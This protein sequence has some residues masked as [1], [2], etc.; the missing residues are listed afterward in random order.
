MESK[1]GG[2]KINGT[3]NKTI[4]LSRRLLL[5][6][7]FFLMGASIVGGLP[8]KVGSNITLI[9]GFVSGMTIVSLAK[10]TMVYPSNIQQGKQ[11]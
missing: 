4:D 7:S 1:N 11:S 5:A 9:G 8:C 10:Y 2:T 6:E 3:E